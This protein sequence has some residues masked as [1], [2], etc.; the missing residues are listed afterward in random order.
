MAFFFEKR[1]Q[2]RSRTI[3]KVLINKSFLLLFF[4][5]EDFLPFA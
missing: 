4:K 2:P 5:K 1:K 3:E